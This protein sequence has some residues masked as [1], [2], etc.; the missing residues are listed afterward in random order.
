MANLSGL[1]NGITTGMTIHAQDE[2]GATYYYYG[3]LDG[4]GKIIIMRAKSDDTEYRYFLSTENDTRTFESE[5][6][7][8]T[9]KTYRKITAL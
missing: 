7:A 4:G 3:Y 8:R 2:S 1:I 6:A 9:T 5:W